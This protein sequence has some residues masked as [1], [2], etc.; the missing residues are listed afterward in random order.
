M[1]STLNK[2]SKKV[3]D[4]LKEFNVQTK[5]LEL[6]SSSRTAKEAAESVGCKIDQIVKSLIL[7][8]KQ[9]N[10]PVLVLASGSN[11]VNEKVIEELVGEP[12]EMAKASF[13]RQETGYS[14]G[15]VPPIG[16][17][18]P[19]KTFIDEDLLEFPFVW[20]AAGTPHSVFQISPDDLVRITNG[21]VIKII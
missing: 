5:V 12:I 20:A 4:T 16:Y 19:I 21:E 10:L 7:I 13:V 14:I 3:Q 8:K 18:S 9:S 6:P 15:G 1:P 2:H 17:H 11:R